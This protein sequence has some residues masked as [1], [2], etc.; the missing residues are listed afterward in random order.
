MGVALVSGGLDSCV[1]VAIGAHEEENVYPD[2]RAN[3]SIPSS[4][5]SPSAP[6]VPFQILEDFLFTGRKSCHSAFVPAEAKPH[7]G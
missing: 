4:R 2:C 1:T 3:S 5:C 6:W 7:S